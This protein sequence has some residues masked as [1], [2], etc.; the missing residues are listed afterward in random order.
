M[1]CNV[2]IWE[3]GGISR[4]ICPQGAITLSLVWFIWK[5][6]TLCN[7]CISYLS[8]LSFFFYFFGGLSNSLT[9]WITIKDNV[10]VT[11]T[12]SK[13]HRFFNWSRFFCI[14]PQPTTMDVLCRDLIMLSR[15]PN[16]IKPFHVTKK[17]NIIYICV[18]C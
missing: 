7:M 18:L 14:S 5:S 13:T 16:N 10:C 6:R 4:G 1:P 17:E 12:F 8:D 11:S 9:L 2:K 3:G 15:F